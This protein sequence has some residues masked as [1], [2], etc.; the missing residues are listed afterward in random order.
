MKIK[1]LMYR[2]YSKLK[3]QEKE[4]YT[5]NSEKYDLNTC[6]QCQMIDS[7]CELYWDSDFNLNGK[8]AL[9]EFCFQKLLEVTK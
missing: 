5:L 2:S 1:D 7:T 9:C 4:F 8:T 3:P 6:D